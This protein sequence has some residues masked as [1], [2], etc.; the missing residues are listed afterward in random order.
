MKDKRVKIAEV[1]LEFELPRQV[2][3][4]QEVQQIESLNK[5]GK[6]FMV[7]FAAGASVGSI[8]MSM[9]FIYLMGLI[10]GLQVQGLSALFAVRMPA[11]ANAMMVM[12]M[13]LATFDIFKTEK[14]YKKIFRFSN[15]DSYS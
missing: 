1:K 11:N 12:V 3:N 9:L 10:N 13:N 8:F 7:I 14:I 5:N 4:E 15:T 2:E 6:I